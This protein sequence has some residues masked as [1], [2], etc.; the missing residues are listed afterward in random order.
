MTFEK[1]P[2]AASS[3]LGSLADLPDREAGNYAIKDKIVEETTVGTL[4]T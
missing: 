1:I 4:E 2:H 3:V